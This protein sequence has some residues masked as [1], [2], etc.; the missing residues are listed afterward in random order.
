MQTTSTISEWPYFVG[1]WPRL[2]GRQ[3]P[4]FQSAFDGD[5]SL[6]DSAAK[7]AYKIG[8]RQMPFQWQTTRKILS[9]QPDSLW[10]HPDVCII[11]VRQVGKTEIALATIIFGLF[12][13]D[14]RIIF[15]GQRW[16]TSERVFQRLKS[17]IE[18]RPSLYRRL[19]K[20]PTTS[21]SRAYI[22]LKS[23]ASITLG[24]RSGDL[25]RGVDRV[26]RLVIDE[27]YSLTDPE[28]GALAPTQLA[29][30]NPQT[31]YLST[32]VDFETQPN[33]QVIAGIR[34][35]GYAREP[36]LYFAEWGA[37]EGMARDEPSTWAYAIPSY[38]EIHTEA[39]VRSLLRKAVTPD[40]L[41]L[42]DA[43]IIGKGNWP[44]EE[45]ELG[46]VISAETWADLKADTPPELVGP[47]AIAVDRSPDRKT[48]AICS[49]QR[50]ADDGRIHLE[51][52]PYQD[53][54]PA[55]VV[56][57]L[58]D[59]V[60]AWDPISICIDARS[61]ANVLEPALV[62]AECP[63]TM[64][65][66]GE[67]VRAC[68][69]FLDAVEAGTISH[70]NQQVLNDA[71]VSA[72]KRDLGGGFAWGSAPGA[73]QLVAASLAHWALL[74]ATTEEPRRSNVPMSGASIYRD[75]P[76]ELDFDKVPF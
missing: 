44:T 45:S 34:R 28:L 62:A 25:G 30:K 51:I 26:D 57:K 15:S 72:V 40:G 6:G 59:I 17:V 69:S 29:S 49:A 71:V 46:S 74:S 56:D 60:M 76:V 37:K 70:A 7:L 42:F 68:G 14:E 5:E 61:A 9:R 13:L 53:L 65:T 39:K 33:C 47:I 19:A 66:T 8:M 27:S 31:I 20:D 50:R 38:G 73:T 12:A 48:W 10:T 11:C 58:L 64:T 2:T 3:A 43:D 24:V 54:W 75:D 36:G 22:E 32:P 4:A 1:E 21:S 16:L 52:G 18:R 41:R 35:K 67:M 63:P 55:D 23:G